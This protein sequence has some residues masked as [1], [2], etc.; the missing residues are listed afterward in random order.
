MSGTAYK[1]G[2]CAGEGRLL[3]NISSDGEGNSYI[4]QPCP[5]CEGK[6]MITKAELMSCQADETLEQDQ[7]IAIPMTGAMRVYVDGAVVQR[8][9]S[10]RQLYKL[11]HYAL[12]VAMETE[13]YEKE[14]K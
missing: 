3:I 11:A 1:C 7:L 4:D 9:M 14:N 6:R 5:I 8:K 13:A 10:S 2:K 12:G